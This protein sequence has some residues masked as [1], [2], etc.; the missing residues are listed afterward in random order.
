MTAPLSP[1]RDYELSSLHAA[2]DRVWKALGVAQYTGKDI[3]EHVTD[4]LAGEYARGKA[5]GLKLAA[6]ECQRRAKIAGDR[7]AVALIDCK[8]LPASAEQ[9]YRHIGEQQEALNCANDLLSLIP[10]AQD[11]K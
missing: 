7:A 2:L 8:T 6:G 1:E 5:D 10:E 9:H 3:A 4:R 11:A